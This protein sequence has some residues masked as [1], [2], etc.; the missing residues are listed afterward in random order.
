MA[1]K[2][3]PAATL[4][5]VRQELDHICYDQTQARHALERLVES[6]EKLQVLVNKLEEQI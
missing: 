3:A 4:I 5:A 6:L 2:K 1:K